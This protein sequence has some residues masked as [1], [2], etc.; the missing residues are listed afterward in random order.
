MEWNVL[1]HNISTR[2]ITTFNIFKHSSF[3]KDVEKYLKECSDKEVFTKELRSTL[4]YYFWCR[5]EYELIISPWCGGR[6]TKEIKVDVYS[7]VMLN[8]DK[9]LDYVWS[10]KKERKNVR[11]RKI[12]Q[13]PTAQ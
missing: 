11:K 5:S 4:M 9:F 6:D 3:L 1:Y 2:E 12:E 13:M 8:W 7:Q 10:F